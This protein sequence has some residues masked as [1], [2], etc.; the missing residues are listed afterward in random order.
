MEL[1]K[2]S[3]LERQQPAGQDCIQIKQVSAEHVRLERDQ[4]GLRV[5]LATGGGEREKVMGIM[6]ALVKP[7]AILSVGGWVRR[8]FPGIVVLPVQLFLTLTVV[9]LELAAHSDLKVGEHQIVD[10]LAEF[11]REFEEG[12]AACVLLRAVISQHRDRKC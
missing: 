12:R 5:D 8:V 1:A 6:D 2:R 11:G 4:A 7:V 10:D 3:Y 9:A